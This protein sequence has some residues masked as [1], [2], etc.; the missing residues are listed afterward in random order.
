MKLRRKKGEADGRWRRRL[1]DDPRQE[2]PTHT[3]DLE[4]VHDQPWVPRSGLIDRLRRS[5]RQ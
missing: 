2:N 1:R 4:P 5:A 3:P